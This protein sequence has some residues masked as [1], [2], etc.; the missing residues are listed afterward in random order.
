MPG[1]KTQAWLAKH[2]GV[3]PAF[4]QFHHQVSS[5]IDKNIASLGE[6]ADSML[7]D[8]GMTIAMF[9]QANSRMKQTRRAA[10]DTLHTAISCLGMPAVTSLVRKQQKLGDDHSLT[11]YSA[12]F[13]QLLNQ[14]YHALKQLD[15]L[16]RMQGITPAEDMHVAV[17]LYNI[18]EIYV[19]LLDFETYRQYL[20]LKDQHNYDAATE[21]F[22]FDFIRLSRTLAFNWTLPELLIE[23]LGDAEK[24][25]RKARLVREAG[26][27]ARLAEFGWY[28]E[29]INTAQANCANFLNITVEELTNNLHQ[30]AI[31]ASNTSPYDEVIS[32]A[33][34]LIQLAAVELPS[35]P[36]QK[37]KPRDI[38]QA[39]SLTGQIKT[40]LKN[41]AANQ[42][43]VLGLLLGSLQKSARFSCVALMLISEDRERLET[44]TAKG[45]DSKQALS[46]LKLDIDKSGIIKKLL[47]KPLA[48]H[49]NGGN[50][51]KYEQFL[52]GQFK[53]ATLC[54]NFVMMAIFVGN[55]PIGLVY[56]DRQTVEQAIDAESYNTFKSYVM[57]ASKALTFLA[58][59][60]AK[61]A[62]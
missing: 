33:E 14:N 31:L 15:S 21:I 38:N 27:I 10:V 47:E 12:H 18:G 61:S 54:D 53:A 50:Y 36:V 37:P 4:D 25:S 23:S 39:L 55:K 60:N 7:L 34:R 45:L 51:K 2:D 22:G 16:A 43:S 20:D 49:I 32:P 26:E 40:L 48:L 13:R 6:I 28:H 8:P 62:A 11:D 29:P 24:M 44:H 58:R 17:L 59:R 1:T 30:A 19:S 35:K 5:L 57:I 9:K 42:W 3:I 52:P 41:P 56:G 46:Q